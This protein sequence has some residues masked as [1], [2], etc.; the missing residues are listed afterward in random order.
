MSCASCHLPEL[1]FSDGEDFSTGIDGM[2]GKRS[3]MSLINIGYVER[4]LFWDG[5][6][7][8]LE[9]QALLPVED[10]LE[11]HNNWENVIAQIKTHP[12]YPT[13]FR[14]AFGIDDTED[15]TKELAAKAIAQFERSLISYQSK[16]DKV[17][18][19]EAGDGTASEER[20]HDMFFDKAAQGSGLPDAECA[21]CHNQPLM[22]SDDFFNN[23][24]DSV[25]SLLDFE[26][27]GH[28]AVTGEELDNGKFRAPTLRNI[29]LTAPYMHDG[30]FQTL[31]EVLD[32]YS[33]H[34]HTTINSDVNARRLNLNASQ[35][36]D[37]INFLHMLTDT[38]FINNPEFQNP[39]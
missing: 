24:I 30:R 15:I 27:V 28:G 22:T 5:R 16:F 39:F 23:G 2:E 14:K 18:L 4:G 20:G 35:K 7:I 17:Y 38:S 25:D 34:I 8:S 12:N 33:D 3:A 21:H 26:D 13:K 37:I 19:L 10:E 11:L 32:H 36:E 6:V 1:S 29:A 9:E 31:E